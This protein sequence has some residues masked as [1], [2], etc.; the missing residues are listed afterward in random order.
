MIS[1]F[2]TSVFT[3]NDINLLRSKLEELPQTEWNFDLEDC[4]KILRIDAPTEISF[5]V[6]DLLKGKGFY[7]EELAD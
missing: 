6:I 3:E 5:T 1:V 4:D 2:K 7:C